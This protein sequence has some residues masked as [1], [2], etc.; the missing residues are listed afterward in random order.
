MRTNEFHERNLPTEVECGDQPVVSASNFE[1]GRAGV[2]AT[3]F[4]TDGPER[5]ARRYSLFPR[6][7]FCRLSQAHS[8]TTAV[9]VDEFDAGG[10]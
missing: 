10:F 6:L 5:L 2:V 7:I 8:G 3:D 4:Y 9:L 1:A